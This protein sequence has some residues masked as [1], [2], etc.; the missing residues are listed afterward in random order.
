V[1]KE[2]T[3]LNK[4]IEQGDMIKELKALLAE[5]A[6]WFEVEAGRDQAQELLAETRE[7]IKCK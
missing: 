2:I 1:D 6:D 3:M 5:W 7:A 4:L